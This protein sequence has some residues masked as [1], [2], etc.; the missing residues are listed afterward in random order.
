MDKETIEM[1]KEDKPT[2]PLKKTG[3]LSLFSSDRLKDKDA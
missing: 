2:E 1:N 3:T